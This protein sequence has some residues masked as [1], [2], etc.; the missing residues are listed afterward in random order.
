MYLLLKPESAKSI[1]RVEPYL[2]ERD[3]K[4]TS[5]HSI[6]DWNALARRIYSPQIES[7]LLFASEFNVYLWLTQSYFGNNAVTLLLERNG[8]G[9]QDLTDLM[10]VKRDF[11]RDLHADDKSPSIILVNLDKSDISRT[12]DIG[13]RG[14]LSVNGTPLHSELDGRWEYFFFKYI[15]TPDPNLEAC[16]R[17]MDVLSRE[18]IFDN[19]ID[20]KDWRQM[21]DMKSL[22]PPRRY[23]ERD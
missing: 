11:R 14:V 16:K 1:D 15:H 18:G 22:T 3:F 23:D 13:K 12:E 19:R 21:V 20:S 4:V 2:E 9:V 10:E 17:E 6:R 5:R 8:G 7:D